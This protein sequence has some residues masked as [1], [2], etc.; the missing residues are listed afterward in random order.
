MNIQMNEEGIRE[1]VRV[2]EKII[3]GVGRDFYPG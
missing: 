1:K 3:Y 2:M